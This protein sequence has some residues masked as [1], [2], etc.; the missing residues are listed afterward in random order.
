[1]Q[2]AASVALVRRSGEQQED[3]CPVGHGLADFVAGSLGAVGLFAQLVGLVHDD[4]VPSSLSD[5]LGDLPV[6]LFPPCPLSR[7]MFAGTSLK[8]N[9]EYVR[10]CAL[11]KLWISIRVMIC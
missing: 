1:M 3:R 6:V 5:S 10:S 8:E 4:H 2:E 11:L 9:V 7:K